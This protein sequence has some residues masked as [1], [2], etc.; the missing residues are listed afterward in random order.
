[1][2]SEICVMPIGVRW[3]LISVPSPGFTLGYLAFR[4]ESCLATLFPLRLDRKSL[5]Q[6]T[7][8]SKVLQSIASVI[9]A[10]PPE[11]EINPIEV[12]FLIFL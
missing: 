3:H 12:I 6:D 4:C 11:E 1:M 2:L 5:R 8:K 9:Q 7:E 10:M